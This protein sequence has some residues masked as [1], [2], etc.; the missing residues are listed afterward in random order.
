MTTPHY[1]IYPFG[2]NA[3]DLTAIPD[4]AAVDGSVS[5]FYGWTDP[6]EY[7]LITNPAA[8]PIPRGQMNQLFFDITNNIQEYQQ[9]GTP[10]WVVGNTVSYPIYARVYYLGLVYQSLISSNTNTPGTDLTWQVVSTGNIINISTTTTLSSSSFGSTVNCGGSAAYTVTLPTPTAGTFI[11]FFCSTTSNALIL[12]SP[13]SGTVQGQTRFA[14]GTGE[15]CTLISDGTNYYVLNY[16]M[17]PASFLVNITGGGQSIA[18][19][20]QTQCQLSVKQYDIGGFFDNVTNYRYQ[21]LYPG[22]YNFYLSTL[23]DQLQNSV[24]VQAYMNLNGSL[25]AFNQSN[26]ISGLSPVSNYCSITLPMNGSTDYVSFWV[27]HNAS[28]AETL[29]GTASQTYAGGYRISNF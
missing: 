16:Y 7:N 24:L 2:Q 1:Y 17:Q 29:L 4:A 5:Y 27:W 21:P 11:N 6:Y 10:Q 8:L 26:T 28:G 25:I 13:P 22:K 20:T 3:D 18:A 23:F 19:S 12:L 15:S 9:Y 14:I